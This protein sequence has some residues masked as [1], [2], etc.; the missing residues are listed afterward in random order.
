M[1]HFLAFRADQPFAGSGMTHCFTGQTP[2]IVA[3]PPVL[4]A[5]RGNLRSRGTQRAEIEG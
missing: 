3:D 2:E 5:R 1:W 4:A